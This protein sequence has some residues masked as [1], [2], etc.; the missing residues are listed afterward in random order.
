[1]SAT[2]KLLILPGDGIG[3]EVVRQVKRVID[4]LGRRRGVSFSV[5]EGLVG[6]PVRQPGEAILYAREQRG[7]GALEMRP[8]TGSMPILRVTAGGVINHV[9]A[10]EPA[11]GRQGDQAIAFL[12]AQH[13][14]KQGPVGPADPRGDADG[15]AINLHLIRRR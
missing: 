15:Q 4:W 2:R 10:F 7:F 6:G 1:M 3:P 13:P 8:E 11:L 9:G 5:S 12:A 14:V